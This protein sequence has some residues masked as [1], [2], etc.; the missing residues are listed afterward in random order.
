[1]AHLRRII[2]SL[3]AAKSAPQRGRVRLR[4]FASEP[5]DVTLPMLSDVMRPTDQVCRGGQDRRLRRGPSDAGRRRQT[6]PRR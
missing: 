1:M 3:A 2:I 5:A 4:E 6:R